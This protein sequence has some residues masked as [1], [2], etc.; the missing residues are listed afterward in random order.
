VFLHGLFGGE[1][2]LQPQPDGSLVSRWNLQPAVLLKGAATCG[3]GG[4]VVLFLQCPRQ[5]V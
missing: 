3:S 2:R 4:V 5:L 1:I